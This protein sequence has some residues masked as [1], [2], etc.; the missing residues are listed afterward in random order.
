ML[1]SV[2]GF[3]RS[4]FCRKRFRDRI[5][6]CCEDSHYRLASLLGSVKERA[7][8]SESIILKIQIDATWFEL[9]SS[10]FVRYSRKFN[11]FGLAWRNSVYVCG[12]A[13]VYALLYSQPSFPSFLGARKIFSVISSRGSVATIR[14]RVADNGR[15]PPENFTRTMSS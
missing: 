4:S 7:Q 8:L 3:S 9:L 5:G 15:E 13:R 2:C 1:Y 12:C 10:D 6:L 14:S 11:S